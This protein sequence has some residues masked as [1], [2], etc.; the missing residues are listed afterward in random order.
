MAKPAAFGGCC[1]QQA[2]RLSGSRLTVDEKDDTTD[3]KPH[4]RCGEIRCRVHETLRVTPAMELGLTNHIWSM[5]E[6][7]ERA[8]ATRAPAP[9][10]PAPPKG[11][12]QLRVIRGGKTA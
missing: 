1:I 11:R 6:L 4:A 7:I 2:T 9:L 10:P 12:P 8:Q 3:R 5:A